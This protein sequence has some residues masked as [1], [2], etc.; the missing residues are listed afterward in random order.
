MFFG[1]TQL[2]YAI[3]QYMI[4]Y[5]DKRN[6]QG[7]GNELLGAR[8]RPLASRQSICDRIEAAADSV[9]CLIFVIAQPRDRVR[10]NIWTIRR[11]SA[12]RCQ[13]EQPAI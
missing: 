9:E 13:G 7:I 6:H 11:Q 4:H 8:M 10:L 3:K 12:Y 1:K 2:E 5:H